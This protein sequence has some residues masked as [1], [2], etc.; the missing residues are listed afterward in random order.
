MRRL[1]A[2][3]T[4]LGLVLLTAAGIAPAGAQDEDAPLAI[5]EVDA[6]DL[7]A[8]DVTF[9][10]SGERDDLAD[11]TVRENGDLVQAA[12]AV[13]YDDQA[14]LGVV[15]VIDASTSMAKDAL[16]ERV[17]EA[18]HQFVDQKMATDQIAIVSF[19]EK[20]TVV[21]DFTTDKDALNQAIDD[22]ALELETSMY[23][24][25]VR[26]AALYR[27]SELQPNIV[28][29]S[30]GEDSTSKAT[31]ANATAAVTAVGGTLFAVGVENPGFDS[32][33]AIARETG[34]T[35]TLASDP[36]GVGAVFDQV[37]QTLRKQYVVTYA[38]EATGGTVPIELTVGT[39]TASA[40]FVAGSSQEGAA[41]LRPQTVEEPT[42]PFGLPAPDFLRSSTGLM[43]ALVLLAVA[44]LIGVWSV[45][46]SF[47]AGDG[48]LNQALQPYADG[49]VS[50]EPEF[51][52]DDGGDGKGQVFAQTPILQRAV[53]ATG[54]FADQRGL[55]V[56]VEAMLERA[57]LPLRPAEALFFYL[58]G[59]VIVALLL[60]LVVGNPLV[61]LIGVIIV[62]LLPPAIV[63][64][65]AN[66]RRK[67]FNSTLPDTLQL[68]ASTL[69]AGYSLMQG[70]EAVSQEVSEPM[71]RELRRVVTE[72]RLGRP[73]EE[74]LEGV[75]TRMESG[76]FAWAVMAI[77]IQREVGGNLAELLVT[78]AETM[79]ERERLRR[80][81]NALTAEGKVSAI[82]LGI[83]PVGLGLFIYTANPGYMDPLFDKTI[84]KILLAGSILL[85]FVGFWWMKKTI[86]V[87]I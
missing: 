46:N 39:D 87:D 64:F 49:Y 43:I 82:V 58:A 38:S 63:T 62:A 40:E 1:A 54:S 13:P 81:V 66:R 52:V 27:D 4:A 2:L 41:A 45:G 44:V 8:V 14:S 7:S 73:L 10:Y 83:L 35:A 37:Q 5:R 71:G 23:D 19:A 47:F 20:V 22:I 12:P 75:A 85:A 69:R 28:V 70:V 76:D 30:D 67:A 33:A 16:I 79:T 57:N 59:V 15:L 25:I 21:E 84:G 55:L 48:N 51:D 11:L 31:Q 42:G 78:V 17:K 86:E 61:A 36:N 74:A 65:L 53:E 24:A 56:K 80:D 34:G 29:F 68:L 32:L 9:F 26:S 60:F 72:A 6:T 18:A 50:A 3:V 77:R